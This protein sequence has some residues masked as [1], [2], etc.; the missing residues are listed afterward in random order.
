MILHLAYRPL[1]YFI[2]SSNCFKGIFLHRLIS[3]CRLFWGIAIPQY[4]HLFSH[5]H[6]SVNFEWKSILLLFAYPPAVLVEY[7]TSPCQCNSNWS[8]PVHVDMKRLTKRYE[9]KN[10]F[11]K[12]NVQFF[13]FHIHSFLKM[14]C[15]R[16]HLCSCFVFGFFWLLFSISTILSLYKWKYF[17]PT[18][19]LMIPCSEM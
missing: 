5:F 14:I 13:H 10:S 6:T 8:M 2:N 9:G 4:H 17:S 15:L 11:K 1:E 7:M 3:F 16:E 18:W 12:I 19:K